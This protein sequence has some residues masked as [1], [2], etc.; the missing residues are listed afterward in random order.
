MNEGDIIKGCKNR[1]ETAYRAFVDGYS[2]FL[3]AIC[4]R[5]M[6]DD[7]RARDCLQESLIQIIT[8]IDKY[9]EQGKFKSWISSVTVKKCLD[10]LR[11]EK[12]FLARNIEDI[13]EPAMSEGTTYILHRDDVMQF[14]ET[15][16]EHYRIAINMFLIEGYSHKEIA[17][18]LNITESSSRSIVSRARKLIVE[19][20]K[21]DEYKGEQFDNGFRLKILRS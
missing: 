14:L 1:E 13:G 6:K 8:K 20:F 3:Y 15:L 7:E 9:E 4:K 16:P 5:Y 19:M 21:E 12:R 17:E 11:K 18:V 2:A 10:Y